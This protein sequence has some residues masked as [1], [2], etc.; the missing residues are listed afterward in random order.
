MSHGKYLSLEE[1]RKTGKL[2]QF[3][4]EHP[5][6]GDGEKFERLLDEMVK[7]RSSPTAGQTSTPAS[8]EGYSETQTRPSTSKDADG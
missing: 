8:S 2:K 3:A 6:A 4:K 7:P 1:A 5:C